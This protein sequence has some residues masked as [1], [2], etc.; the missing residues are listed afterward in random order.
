MASG[1]K[2]LAGAINDEDSFCNKRK[3]R[4]TEMEIE[5][6]V[7][8]DAGVLYD[9]MLHHTYSSFSGVLGTAVGA[10]ILVGFAATGYVIYLIAGIVILAYLP[11]SLFLRSRQQMLNTPAFKEPLHYRMTQEGVEIS[12]KEA[13][14]F[15]KWEDMYKAVSTSKSIILYTSSVKASIFPRSDLGDQ[16]AAVI[17]MIS[18]HMPPKKVKIKA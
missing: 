8:I 14:E 15:Q 9:Y 10:L 17:E 7:R 16:Q 6:D 3:E 12:Q 2:R 4:K 11:W 13:K 18:R 1:D 5:F